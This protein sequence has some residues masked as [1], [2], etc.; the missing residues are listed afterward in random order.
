MSEWTIVYLSTYLLR[1]ILVAYRFWQL[2]IKKLQNLSSGFCVD[3]NFQLTC[4]NTMECEGWLVWREYVQFCGNHRLSPQQPCIWC[5][6][7]SCAYL[8]SVYIIWWGVCLSLFYTFNWVVYFSLSFKNSLY[9]CPLSDMC[10]AN[11]FICLW[12]AF[13]FLGTQFS[14]VQ[15]LSC[16]RLFVTPWIAARQ[17]SLSITNS[18]SLL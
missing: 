2:W 8:P 16:V 7:L 14:S 4:V 9:T 15:S 12:L 10:F 13:S 5:Q 6:C 1:D 3:V 17:A 11:I 18:W